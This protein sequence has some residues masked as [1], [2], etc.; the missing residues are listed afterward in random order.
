MREP[1][2]CQKQKQESKKQGRAPEEII[3]YRNFFII[4]QENTW[5]LFT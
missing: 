2:V 5:K 4:A 1:E 3:L